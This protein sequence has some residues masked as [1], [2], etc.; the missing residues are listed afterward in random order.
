MSRTLRRERLALS[1]GVTLDVLTGGPGTGPAVLFLHGFPESARTWRHQMTDLAAS[2]RVA[3]PDQRGFAGSDKPPEVS[4][5]RIGRL[6]D[7]VFALADALGFDRFCLVGHDWGGA[8][9]WAAALR[10][11]ARLTGLIIA[12]GPH[13]FVFQDCLW[14]DAAQRQAS[15]YIDDYRAPDK[16]ARIRAAGLDAFID[17]ALGRHVPAELLTPEVRAAYLAEWSVPRALEAMLNW[18]RASPLHVPPTDDTGPRPAWLDQSFPKLRVP[19]LVI[20]GMQDKALLP[21][22]LDGLAAHVPDLTVARIEAGHFLTWQAPE[23]V[24]AAIRSFLRSLAWRQAP[25]PCL[26]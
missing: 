20:W 24:T 3:A 18:Y 4:D 19:A 1:T 21:I 25:P 7:D 17:T 8:V 2:Y 14:R 13:P 11:P 10:D 15:R 26:F 9:A 22:Q 12:N 16:A 5:Y 23:A 6:V